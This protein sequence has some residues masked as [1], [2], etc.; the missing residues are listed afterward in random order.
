MNKTELLEVLQD[1]RQEQVDLLEGLPDEMMLIPLEPG[2]WT[3]KDILAH[4][5]Y[6]EG[7]TVTLLFQASRGVKKPTTVH[8]GSE[9]GEELNQ[10]WHAASQE[11]SLEIIWQDWL[12]VRKQ[13]IRRAGDMSEKDLT[14]PTRFDWMQGKPLA[15][16]IYSDA[17]DH[18]EKHADY[19]RAWLDQQDTPPP[20]TNGRGH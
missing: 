15:E 4:L 13:L 14:D 1:S 16:L 20:A 2:G 17:V 8:F 3:I 10:R 18:E 12:G 19:I 7:Q 11:R 9:T 6:W 5:T